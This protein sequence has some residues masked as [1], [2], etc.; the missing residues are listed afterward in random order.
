MAGI[1][2][3]GGL[4]HV[5]LLVAAHPVLGAEGGAQPQVRPTHQGVQAVLTTPRHRGRVAEQGK[6]PPAQPAGKL[7]VCEQAVDT[8]F[9]RGFIGGGTETGWMLEWTCP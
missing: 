4:D 3:V 8:E 9:H 7:R 2:D 1:C 5:V 6:A